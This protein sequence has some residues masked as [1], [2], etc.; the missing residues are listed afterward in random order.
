MLSASVATTEWKSFIETNRWEPEYLNSADYMKY[1]RAEEMKLRS[2]LTDLGL[3]KQSSELTG[4]MTFMRI[5]LIRAAS[6]AA[7]AGATLLPLA[8]AHAQF[9][10]KPGYRALFAQLEKTDVVVEGAKEPRSVVYVFFDANCYYCNL[11]WKVFQVYEKVGLQVRWV[12]VAYQQDSSWGRAAA[13][14]QAADR[15]AALRENEL[16]YEVKTFSGG[17]RPVEKPQET[18]LA[19]LRSNNKLIDKTCVSGTPALIW[20]DRNGNV[21]C[22]PGTPRLSEIPAITGLPEQPIHDPELAKLR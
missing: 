12:P 7:F 9:V 19:A 15:A 5:L 21:Q 2:T 20:K 22:K 8:P 10:S 1:L 13:I 6:A 16:K 14:M 17:I 3:A 11:T 4:I 18:V